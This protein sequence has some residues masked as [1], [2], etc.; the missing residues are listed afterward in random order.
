M[1]ARLDTLGYPS[2]TTYMHVL[3]HLD[4]PHALHASIDVQTV[5]HTVYFLVTLSTK[6]SNVHAG[7][8][9]PSSGHKKCH[10]V[11]TLLRQKPTTTPKWNLIPRLPPAEIFQPVV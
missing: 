5:T 6:K 1:H 11:E 2:R 4:T 9:V 3:I 7:E 10:L 8:S